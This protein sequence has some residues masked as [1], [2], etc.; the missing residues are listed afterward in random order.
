M[1]ISEAMSVQQAE[2][3]V[4]QGF[5]TCGRAALSSETLHSIWAS[6]DSDACSW[7][8]MKGLK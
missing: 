8:R 5:S 7:L 6:G 3:A 2:A 4:G 1:F